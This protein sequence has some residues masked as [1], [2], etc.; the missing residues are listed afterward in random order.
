M[1]PHPEAGP[2]RQGRGQ[3]PSSQA[4]ERPPPR[5]SRPGARSPRTPRRCSILLSEHML[6]PTAAGGG[7]ASRCQTPGGHVI[8]RLLWRDAGKERGAGG[9][10][11]GRGDR[12]IGG[13][14]RAAAGEETTPPRPPPPSPRPLGLLQSGG[15]ESMV[16]GPLP[17]QSPSQAPARWRRQRACAP[18]A[19][20]PWPPPPAAPEAAPRMA[21]PGAPRSAAA[22]SPPPPGPPPT[23]PSPP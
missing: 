11:A 20:H 3:Q 1:R 9:G 22:P 23:L 13:A 8:W 19:P 2:R 10:G 14:S 5:Q 4:S 12:G 21:P 7:G 16:G 15:S 6:Q 18:A 17:A